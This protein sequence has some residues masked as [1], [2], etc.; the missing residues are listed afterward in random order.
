MSLHPEDKAQLIQLL[1]QTTC[2]VCGKQMYWDDSDTGEGSVYSDAGLKET[3]ITGMCEH[4]F[5]V[6]TM[7]PDE[8][9][10]DDPKPWIEENMAHSDEVNDRFSDLLDDRV[11]DEHDDRL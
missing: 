8:D 6:I 11:P 9:E 1:D 7:P 10:P 5:D 2:V 3:Q 4:C